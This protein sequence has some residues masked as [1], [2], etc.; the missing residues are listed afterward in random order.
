MNKKTVKE[1]IEQGLKIGDKVWIK[2]KVKDIDRVNT[3]IPLKV[4][5]D[6]FGCE[7]EIYLPTDT[8]P[9][10]EP[11]LEVG[12]Y[13]HH[14][15]NGAEWLVGK[16]TQGAYFVCECTKE[17]GIWAFSEIE[18]WDLDELNHIGYVLGRH[19]D[20]IEAAPE[21]LTLAECKPG[22]GDVLELILDDKE[23][24]EKKVSQI[25]DGVV[26]FGAFSFLPLSNVNKFCRVKSRAPKPEQWQPKEGELVWNSMLKMKCRVFID[27]Y[28][29]ALR[30]AGCD[31]K[32]G[33]WHSSS[34]FEGCEP[35][36]NQDK[37]SIDF[38]VAGQWITDGEVTCMTAGE[39]YGDED[40]WAY[41]LGDMKTQCHYKKYLNWQLLTPEQMR[42]I[43]ELIKNI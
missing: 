30:W 3:E 5:S 16:K 17:G 27:I 10:P 23:V 13:W 22:V 42:P 32:T 43:L 34:D 36:T 31:L 38:S 7:E 6:W 18:S 19:P 28:S 21:W 11:K 37:P 25:L 2:E 4:F 24:I 9:V 15:E 41:V 14:P 8:A 39:I 29:D 20:N 1:A 12:Q 26:Y 33:D 35:Y 40:F